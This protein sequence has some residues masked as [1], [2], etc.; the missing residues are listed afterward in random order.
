MESAAPPLGHLP[1]LGRP[2]RPSRRPGLR[3]A[4]DGAHRPGCPVNLSARSRSR[5]TSARMR[6]RLALR[7]RCARDRRGF[8]GFP[9]RP[10]RVIHGI[11]RGPLVSRST[12]PMRWRSCRRACWCAPAACAD[13]VVG[14]L[15]RL[16]ARDH[17]PARRAGRETRRHR[18]PVGRPGHQQDARRSPAA[19]GT[20][21]AC[22]RTSC[23][24]RCR[25]R[26]RTHR[27]AAQARPC[28]RSPVR[29]PSSENSHDKTERPGAR[30]PR[31]AGLAARAVHAARGRDLP[32]RQLAGR[33][34]CRR[35]RRVWRR[36]CSRNGAR[37]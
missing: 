17:R 3:A 34:A 12:S 15:R 22:S 18:Q 31:P 20:T 21:C 14:R 8:A 29:A 33:A 11:G 6:M 4:L 35:R 37:A 19:A 16:R 2:R 1:V 27:A 9:P 5:R 13:G 28:L 25:R 32:R 7:R 36:R 30:R 23:W 10:C 26:L 24:T